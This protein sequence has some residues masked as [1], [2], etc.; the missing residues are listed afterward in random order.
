MTRSPLD[1]AAL[2]LR[3]RAGLNAEL[4]SRT[5]LERLLQE[6]AN[7]AGIPVHTYVNL[8]DDQPAAFDDLVDR[9]TVQHSAFFRDAA[10]FVALAELAR[11]ASADPHTVWSAGC[12]NGQEPYSLAMLLD[13]TGVLNWH[14]VATD[15]SFHALARTETG[16]YTER[17]VQ[18]LSLERRRRYLVPNAS[19]Y[20]IAPFIRRRVRI[21]HHNLAHSD[22]ASCVPESAVVFCRNVLMYFGREESEASIQRIAERVVPGGHLFLGHSDSPGRMARY[23]EAVRVAGVP[24]HRRLPAAAPAAP[25]AGRRRD[26]LRPPPDLPGL[27]A[28]GDHAASHGDL[29]AAVRAFRQATYLDPNL[30]IAYFQLGAALDLAGD[31]REARRA[32]GAAGLAMMRADGAEDISGLGGYTRR[33]LARAIASKLTED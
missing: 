25:I 14:I 21:A 2:L 4:A 23:F 5:R 12:G 20:E 22:A 31:P 6:S 29:R 18:G 27:L 13:E 28:E 19:G 17:E 33:D 11:N 16:L 24:C 15:V 30:A 10:Q 1:H 7:I 3:S 9:V 26:D 8:V 32:F